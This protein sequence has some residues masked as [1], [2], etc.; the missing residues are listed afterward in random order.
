MDTQQIEP[1]LEHALGTS[2]QMITCS[3]VGG[4]CINY[5]Y[6][7]AIPGST[8]FLKINSANY[9]EMFEA[10]FLGLKALKNN[11]SFKVPAPIHTG[12]LTNSSYLL[13][14]FIESSAMKPDYWDLL[15]RGLADMHRNTNEHFG[16]E[17]DNYIGKL[18]QSNR[19]HE[20]W[21]DFLIQERYLPQIELATKSRVLPHVKRLKFEEL[22]VKL[23]Q[24]LTIEL[25]AFLHGDLWSGNLMVG[26]EGE[27]AIMD[28][29]VYYGHREI[30]LAFT[31]LFG[32]F[33]ARFYQVYNE[34]YPLEP[35]YQDRFELYN[36]YPL[37]VHLNLFGSSY[38]GDIAN[39]LD[40][41]V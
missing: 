3:P 40:K 18:P 4:G 23:D 9:Q 33:S 38:L 25:P 36:L 15:G 20:N 22:F 21:L 2:A 32:G 35:G 11:F 24:L 26:R 19:K 10:E 1:I 14:E 17:I 5:C 29:A 7:V 31:T 6:R 8:Y 12:Q 30:E 37:L 41:Y 34:N 27:P 13:M 39:I 16:Y 28:P